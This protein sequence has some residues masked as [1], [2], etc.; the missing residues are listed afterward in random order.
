MARA[1]ST[2]N[3]ALNATLASPRVKTNMKSH[4]GSTAG[5]SSL[6]MM[7]P[8]ASGRFPWHACTVLMHP[9]WQSAL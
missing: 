3:A 2:L 1:K 9:V 7:A 4:G 6:S 8:R 5:K